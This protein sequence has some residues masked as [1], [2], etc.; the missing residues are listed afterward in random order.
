[1]VTVLFRNPSARCSAPT[2]PIL[3]LER[4][5]AVNVC[6]KKWIRWYEEEKERKMVT[7]LFRNPSARCSAPTSPISSCE[8]FSVVSVCVKSG[9]GDM[10]KKKR[11]R[12]SLCCS[13]MHR[14]DVLFPH[15]RFYCMRDVVWW[16]SV[17]KSGY[18]DMKKKMRESES[19]Y[20]GVVHRPDV[21]LPLHRFDCCGDLVWWV[22]MWKSG[23]CNMK[24]KKR[25]RWSPCYF[26]LL[27]KIEINGSVCVCVSLND[28][29]K[30]EAGRHVF[31]MYYDRPT[32][33]YFEVDK[34]TDDVVIAYFVS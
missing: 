9:Y 8:R 6:V 14:P 19:P 31:G 20:C 18:G 30:G 15:L 17:W 23:Y 3:L 25:E 29:L 1:M 28:L 21:V 2:G 5:S 10:R 11:E 26:T 16:V 22:S 24:K 27:M 13:V 32:W 7:L 33:C 34:R 4:S 12:W